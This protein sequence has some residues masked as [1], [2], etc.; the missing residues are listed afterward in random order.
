MEVNLTVKR[1]ASAA[2]NA[3][4]IDSTTTVLRIAHV[5]DVNDIKC[6]IAHR[7]NRPMINLSL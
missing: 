7:K 2:T 3:P 4:M 6:W 5:D 1:P